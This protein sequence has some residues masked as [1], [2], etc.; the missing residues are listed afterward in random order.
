MVK[1]LNPLMLPPQTVHGSLPKA[2][3]SVR[4]ALPKTMVIAAVMASRMPR[5]ATSIMRGDLARSRIYMYRP[6]YRARPTVPASR[7]DTTQLR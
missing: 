7:H 4:G 3:G 1:T 5:E 6:L 2:S